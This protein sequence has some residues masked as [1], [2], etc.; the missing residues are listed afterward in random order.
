MR[1]AALGG[2]GCAELRFA[3]ASAFSLCGVRPFAGVAALEG[4]ALGRAP[5]Q[6]VS[7]DSFA[8]RT[9]PSDEEEENAAASGASEQEEGKLQ[10]EAVAGSVKSES[11]LLRA[12]IKTTPAEE[13]REAQQPPSI[14]AGSACPVAEASVVVKAEDVSAQA[15]QQQQLA[16]QP[17]TTVEETSPPPV[18]EPPFAGAGEGVEVAEEKRQPRVFSVRRFGHFCACCL[19]LDAL[20]ERREAEAAT[21][22]RSKKSRLSGAGREADSYPPSGSSGLD[23]SVRFSALLC[24][25]KKAADA[26][27]FCEF[28]AP[29]LAAADTN[30]GGASRE[31]ERDGLSRGASGCRAESGEAAPFRAS[32]TSVMTVSAQAIRDV[33]ADCREW[34]R[35]RVCLERKTNGEPASLR[36]GGCRCAAAAPGEEEVLAASGCAEPNCYRAFK[37]KADA[38]GFYSRSRQVLLLDA[39]PW[40]SDVKLHPNGGRGLPAG[41]ERSSV[42]AETRRLWRLSCKGA[43][44]ASLCAALR[45]LRRRR[46]G[47]LSDSD[48]DVHPRRTRRCPERTPVCTRR[49]A[50]RKQ[51]PR[52]RRR[53][54]CE[55]RTDSAPVC[56][57]LQRR[58]PYAL[59]DGQSPQSEA[60]RYVRRFLG[61]GGRRKTPRPTPPFGD[62]EFEAAPAIFVRRRRACVVRAVQNYCLE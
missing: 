28:W 62:C 38:L 60:R 61:S 40:T 37:R 25:L 18:P 59:R 32:E 4:V 9:T 21:P 50:E 17:A 55:R 30:G 34:L 41:E 31:R 56:D 46:R 13:A 44:R 47:T 19:A 10:G 12:A 42:S 39:P 48:G 8:W 54:T 16:E 14:E 51:P 58:P 26:R 2:E 20:E 49:A 24:R 53:L 33:T 35:R 52:E 5:V 3:A 43:S 7:Y 45:F 27:R 36:E 29:V 22:G 1:R 57:A 11:P 15:T 6:A 23:W